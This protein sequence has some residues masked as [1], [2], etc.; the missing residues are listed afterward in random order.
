MALPARRFCGKQGRNMDEKLKKKKQKKAKLFTMKLM[1]TVCVLIFAGSAF[2]VGYQLVNNH[3]HDAA[4]QELNDR[5]PDPEPI[6]IVIENDNVGEDAEEA[7]ETTAQE[8][9]PLIERVSPQQWK[10]WWETQ[11]SSRFPVYQDLLRQNPDFVG[12]VRIEGTGL[13]YPV[14]QTPDNPEY[15]LHR[16]FE[17]NYSNYGTPFMYEDCSLEEPKTNLII[18]GHHMKNGKMFA[19]LQNYTSYIY[20]AEHPY[21]QFDTVDSSGSYEIAA[22]IYADPDGSQVPWNDLL[23]S[24]QSETFQNAWNTIRRRSFIE[25][26]I[27]LKPEDELLALVTC[28]YS[29]QDGRLMVIARKIR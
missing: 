1:L 14:C 26:G 16:D 25:T 20:Y 10:S 9:A 3:I 5:F 29:H 13:D 11:S 17:G 18:C 7:E 15:Y 2:M 21:I 6:E 23:F 28:E 27:N 8:T 19:S 24:N 22:A 12:W 4:F